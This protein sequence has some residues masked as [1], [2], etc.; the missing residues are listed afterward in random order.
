MDQQATTSTTRRRRGTREDTENEILDAALR[1][2]E[3]DGV[4]A[5]ITLR[6]VAKEAGVNHGQI[7]QYFGTRQTLL[8]AAITRMVDRDR[9]DPNQHW[10]QPFAARR[11]AMWHWALRQP[12]LVKLEALLALDGDTELNLFPAIDRTQAA[13][14]RDQESGVL[15][16]DADG[17][18]MHAL[19]AA[20]YLGYCVFRE[21][22]ARNL[23]IDTAELDQR[24][25]AVYSDM[26]DGL[27]GTRIPDP[28]SRVD[29]ED[30]GT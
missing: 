14:E 22:M 19:T 7:Y 24:A 20:T 16:S 27:Q 11:E 1:L 8:R 23:G 18:V 13:L 6:E 4:L 28:C 21:V 26:L 15:P 17:V 12:D 25:A 3:R 30:V 29:G 2:M 9:P 10:D 5:G